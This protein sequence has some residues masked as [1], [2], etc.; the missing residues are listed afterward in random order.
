LGEI[1]GGI[2]PAGAD[3]H[4]KTANSALTRIRDAFKRNDCHPHT[5]FTGAAI[6][7]SMAKEIYSQLQN[8]ELSNAANL[9]NEQQVVSLCSWL[10]DL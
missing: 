10:L 2:D 7:T 5:F 9:T 4:W 1:K 6:E 8:K 3:E